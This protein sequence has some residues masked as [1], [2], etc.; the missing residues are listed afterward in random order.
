MA[1]KEEKPK[2]EE[3]AKKEDEKPEEEELE[4]I[5]GLS[6]KLKECVEALAKHSIVLGDDLPEDVE[7][8]LDRLIAACKTKQAV[9]NPGSLDNPE[10]EARE[11]ESP[12]MMSLL[13]DNLNLRIDKLFAKKQITKPM[14][15]KLLAEVGTVKLSQNGTSSLLNKIEAYEDLPENYTAH[16]REVN[17]SQAKEAELPEEAKTREAS[18]KRQTEAGSTMANMAMGKR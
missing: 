1:D 14:K 9:E 8:F 15:D 16:Q 13:R 11:V 18:E 4:E 7:Q 2:K 12:V 10:E 5:S 3:A 17:L 6:E